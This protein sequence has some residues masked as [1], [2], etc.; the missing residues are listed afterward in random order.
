[1]GSVVIFPQSRVVRT[2]ARSPRVEELEMRILEHLRILQHRSSDETV[3]EILRLREEI[4]RLEA[5]DASAPRA[6]MGW[7]RGH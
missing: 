5:D 3:G 4:W 1:M 6:G 2:H 7:P